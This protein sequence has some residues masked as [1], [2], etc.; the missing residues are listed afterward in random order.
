M[1]AK[2]R[3]YFNITNDVGKISCPIT[4]SGPDSIMVGNGQNIH[5]S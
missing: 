1:D 5:I 2:Y 3:G 4:Y